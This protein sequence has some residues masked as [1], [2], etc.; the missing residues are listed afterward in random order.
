[1]LLFEDVAELVALV[2]V[3]LGENRHLG[4]D[5]PEFLSPLVRRIFHH[6]FEGL[7]IK[8]IENTRQRADN[9]SSSRCVVHE[10]ELT[11][12][13]AGF[14]GLDEGLM[15]VE[16]LGTGILTGTHHVEGEAL[17]TLFDHSVT[18]VEG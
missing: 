17:V 11:E 16:V 14:V 2:R 7:P 5:C 4:D 18:F 3:D 9:S 13:L 1:V 8:C 6:T 15:T 12:G 10:G